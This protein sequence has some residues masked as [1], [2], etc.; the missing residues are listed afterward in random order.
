MEV[1]LPRQLE[2]KHS[3]TANCKSRIHIKLSQK[4]KESNTENDSP[5]VYSNYGI[6]IL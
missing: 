5:N 1:N 2:H 3:S 4:D 6:Q